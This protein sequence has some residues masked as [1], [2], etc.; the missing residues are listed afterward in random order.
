MMAKVWPYFLDVQVFN[1]CFYYLNVI[2]VLSEQ[3]VN[4]K[5]G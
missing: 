4:V 1:L 5:T 2:I 3:C